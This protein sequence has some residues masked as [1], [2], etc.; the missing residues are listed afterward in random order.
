MNDQKYSNL[1]NDELIRKHDLA[2]PRY[3]S[4]PTAPQFDESFGRN[5]WLR[6]AEKSNSANAPLS[7]YFHI[8]FCDTVCYYCACNKIITANKKLAIPYVEALKKEID[9][10]AIYIDRSRPVD[11]LH[12]GGG[13]PTYLTDEQMHD[14]MAHT[15]SA[16][17]LLGD[18]SGEYSIEIHPKGVSPERLTKLRALGFNRLSMGVQDFDE[19]VQVAVNRFNSEEEVLALV[20]AARALDFK[21]ISLDL[22]YGLPLQTSASF[23]KTLERVLALKPDRLSVFNYAHLPDLFK[24]QKQIDSSQLPEPQEK[25]TILRQSI[26]TLLQAGYVYVGM[27]HFALPE[28]ELAKAQQAKNLHR[29]F[30]GY[31][32]HGNCEMFSFGVSSISAF[33]DTFFQNH[34][35]IDA[36]YASLGE[37]E[38]PLWRGIALSEDDKI[39]QTVIRE[40]ICHFELPFSKIESQYPIAFSKYFA[41]ELAS[42]KSLEA[43]G[44]LSI[45]D[46]SI[47]VNE[48][49][50]L[51][52]RRICMAFDKYLSASAR[53]QLNAKAKPKYS[54]II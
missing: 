23:A 17:N 42:L 50:R 12:W 24:T 20:Q 46:N 33:G 41:A 39:R 18:D 16:F 6:A 9:M 38:L 34:K 5:E 7:L 48:S 22:I 27:D 25:L 3:T 14:L 26:D 32:T 49:G 44:L 21:S 8:P 30:Q 54:R 29:N 36:Y 37:D 43:D 10:Q 11:Q 53:D 19:N 2:G 13:T 45:G 47:D 40:L 1:W 15:R 52:I 4:Y 35:T 51:L 31:A 28:D